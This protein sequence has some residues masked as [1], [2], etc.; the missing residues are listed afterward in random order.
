MVSYHYHWHQIMIFRVG[1]LHAIGFVWQSLTS[2]VTSV[3]RL[4]N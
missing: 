3:T 1:S 2:F 4:G